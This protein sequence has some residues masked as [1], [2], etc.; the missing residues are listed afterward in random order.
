MKYLFEI[1]HP[2]HVHLFRNAIKEL[3]SEGHE[4]I[5]T[6]REKDV[7]TDLLDHYGFDHHVLSSIGDSALQIPLEWGQREVKLFQIAR[8]ERP[9][10]IVSR[11][12]PAAAHVSSVLGIKSIQFDDSEGASYPLRRATYGF[13][14]EVYT[15]QCFSLD[16]GSNQHR[17]TGYHELAYLHPNRFSPDPS[18]LRDMGI[19]EQDELVFVRLVDWS[20]HHDINQKGISNPVDTVEDLEETGANVVI[21]T[22]GQLPSEIEDKNYEF[23]IH[24][25]HNLL[26]YSDLFIGESATMASESA[27][28]G[29]P[30]IYTATISTGYI[31]ELDKKHGL[32]HNL[33]DSEGSYNITS[34]ATDIL[35]NGADYEE[36]RKSMLEECRD[37]TNVILESI[38][39]TGND[40]NKHE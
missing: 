11:F 31:E 4:V 3:E 23:P 16:I 8:K 2:A 21:S 22:E 26:Y 39:E 30:A 18:T 12:N 29:T 14:D 40:E 19:D 36:K 5:I 20:S 34:L 37:T 25:V 38:V 10:V 35:S 7:T 28:L 32:V 13:V 24:E 15:P 33:S 9:D 1:T 17:Y 27:V 6:S